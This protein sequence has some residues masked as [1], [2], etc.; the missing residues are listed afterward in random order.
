M[1]FIK[2]IGAG[3]LALGVS[4]PV[5]ADM[6]KEQ[7]I[8]KIEAGLSQAQR[9][10]DRDQYTTAVEALMRSG[11]APEKCVELVTSALAR[12]VP[13]TEVAALARDVEA[14]AQDDKAQAEQYAREQFASAESR[15]EARDET[16]HALR[17]D[18][19]QDMRQD[20]GSP[21]HSEHSYGG[22]GVG[23][24]IGSGDFAG[25]AGAGAGSGHGGQR[26]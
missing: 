24:G 25:G 14:R 10:R 23:S 11:V 26:Y 15:Q 7:A 21:V 18:M 20:I 17:Q 19:Q 13:V 8:A 3:V 5:W 2:T 1:N 12:D 9:E 16:S 4:L 22:S 6:T